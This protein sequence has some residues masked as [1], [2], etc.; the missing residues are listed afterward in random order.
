[1]EYDIYV[2][3]SSEDVHTLG[4][5]VEVE[6][7]LVNMRKYENGLLRILTTEGLK[8]EVLDFLNELKYMIPLEIVEIRV[9]NGDI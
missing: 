5:I 8:E 6:D 9:N 1:M 4:Y 2:K 3:I 7:N